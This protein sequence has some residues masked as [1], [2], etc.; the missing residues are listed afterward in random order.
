MPSRDIWRPSAW[1]ENG[2]PRFT[3]GCL[4]SGVTD[5]AG[6]APVHNDSVLSYRVGPA[7]PSSTTLRQFRCRESPPP[8]P[9]LQRR[10]PQGSFG[11][12]TPVTRSPIPYASRHNGLPLPT[13]S[14][15][16]ETEEDPSSTRLSTASSSAVTTRVPT[17]TLK[18][19]QIMP[20]TPRPM[21]RL[22]MALERNL[23]CF[24]S[25]RHLYRTRIMHCS[26]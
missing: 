23:H 5:L 9:S 10:Q 17:T 12:P 8:Q 11:V 14:S 6:I 21:P 1:F 2:L 18:H 7:L 13:G 26:C 15:E 20:P 25:T 19:R 4:V 22:G 16:E 3:E 24:L